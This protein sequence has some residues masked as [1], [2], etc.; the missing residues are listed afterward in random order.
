MQDRC[1]TIEACDGGGGVVVVGVAVVVG[2]PLPPPVVA[3][4]E[5]LEEGGAEREDLGD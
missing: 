2:V 3:G 1:C 4:V 5:A